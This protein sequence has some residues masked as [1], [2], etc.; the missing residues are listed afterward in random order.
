MLVARMAAAASTGD[1]STSR[2]ARMM[3][4][5]GTVGFSAARIA[6]SAIRS[7]STDALEVCIAA[8][9]SWLI[10]WLVSPTT[11]DP[12]AVGTCATEAS[13]PLGSTF[14]FTAEADSNIPV[15]PATRSACTVSR[16]APPDAGQARSV[17]GARPASAASTRVAIGSGSP[18]D[19]V[20]P[21]R[22]SDSKSGSAYGVSCTV[23]SGSSRS[24]VPSRVS[25]AFAASAPRPATGFALPSRTVYFPVFIT[26]SSSSS[27]GSMTRV[28]GTSAPTFSTTAS[29]R[30]SRPPIAT[31]SA[32]SSSVNTVSSASRCGRSS[33]GHT[34]LT[35]TGR[36][37]AAVVLVR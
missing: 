22:V 3:T 15:T 16:L 17:C 25:Q 4:T 28:S 23:T 35:P 26:S 30:D 27:S 32:R 13:T 33:S 29:A 14:G 34:Q 21:R 2:G 9:A 24:T 37:C 19:Q 1:G 12:S 10:A 8:P 5:C 6:I 7:G 36:A 20:S 11:I 31:E 18:V